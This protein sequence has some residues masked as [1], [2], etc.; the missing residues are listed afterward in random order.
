MA[1]RWDCSTVPHVCTLTP[2]A[3][4]P[5]GMGCP[6]FPLA[7]PAGNVWAYREHSSPIP[8]CL[9]INQRRRTLC[10]V[11]CDNRVCHSPKSFF[12]PLCITGPSSKAH[13]G[14][15]ICALVR[16]GQQDRQEDVSNILY[17]EGREAKV[18]IA[19][20]LE[21]QK[22]PTSKPG[23]C[24]EEGKSILCMGAGTETAMGG[25]RPS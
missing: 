22:V 20:H 14:W 2:Q 4:P 16:G 9:N 11:V 23:L 21:V 5:E 10:A 18:S 8:M 17:R 12:S 19:Q 24:N 3:Q 1:W 25:T 6:V 15:V 13:R 7:L